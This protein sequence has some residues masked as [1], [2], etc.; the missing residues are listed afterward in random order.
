LLFSFAQTSQH[1]VR[2]VIL[3]FV[4]VAKTDIEILGELK[5][6]VSSKCFLK[7]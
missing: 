5:P 1:Y 3:C 2:D 4:G 6:F 7:L